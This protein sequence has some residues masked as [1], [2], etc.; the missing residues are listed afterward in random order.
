MEHNS[1]GFRGFV[2]PHAPGHLPANEV[3]E[4]AEQK[5]QEA[6]RLDAEQ[7]VESLRKVILYGG[8]MGVFIA[9]IVGI[10]LFYLIM[11]KEY[12]VDAGIY[13]KNS[14]FSLIWPI[15]FFILAY[16]MSVMIKNRW[17][18]ALPVVKNTVY[19][20]I[21]LNVAEQL[22]ISH[23]QGLFFTLFEVGWCVCALVKIGNT[24]KDLFCCN[25]P[26]RKM[27]CWLSIGLLL[28]VKVGMGIFS[29][30]LA[31]FVFFD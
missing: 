28:A 6:K 24:D 9:R 20:L 23:G 4:I 18:D 16:Y 31:N 14:L 3:K 19:T 27:N 17:K 1:S 7:H 29:Y 2:D 30:I 15:A 11:A 13:F 22:F 26:I 8:V 12:M 10:F 5:R 21:G 25:C